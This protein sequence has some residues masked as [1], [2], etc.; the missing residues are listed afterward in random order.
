VVAENIRTMKETYHWT[1]IPIIIGSFLHQIFWRQWRL[2]SMYCNRSKHPDLKKYIRYMELILDMV[3][4][5][6]SHTPNI[7]ELPEF[8]VR[9]MT[10]DALVGERTLYRRVL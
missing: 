3:W 9:W 2:S 10:I 7:S 8:I 4:I 6:L 5:H 1:E